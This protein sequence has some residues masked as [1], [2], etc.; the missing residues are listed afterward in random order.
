MGSLDVR[1]TWEMWGSRG[2]RTEV[3]LSVSDSLRSEQVERFRR[4]MK[5]LLRVGAR[6]RAMCGRGVYELMVW[7]TI[8]N[9]MEEKSSS[10][11]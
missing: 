2:Q 6:R 8:S 3:R 7:N 1:E 5:V 11:Q 4:C 9:G 10:P